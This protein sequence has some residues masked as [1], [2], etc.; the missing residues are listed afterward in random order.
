[1]SKKVHV[2]RTFA[3][4]QFEALEPHRFEDLVRDLLYEYRDWQRIEATGRGGADEGFD[5]RAYEKALNPTKSETDDEEESEGVVVSEGNLWMI[6]CKREKQLSA[7]RIVAIIDEAIHKDDPPYGYVLAAPV[8]FTKKSYDA[9]RSAL[10]ERG[11]FEYQLLGR[12]ELEDMLYQPKNDRVLFAFFGVSL[13]SQKRSRVTSIRATV[14]MKN[15]LYKILGGRGH[16]AFFTD[17]LIRDTDDTEYPNKEAYPDFEN[18]PR[19][20]V[21]TACGH[22]VHGVRFHVR[23]HYA[24]VDVI[25]KEWDFIKTPNLA[26]VVDPLSQDAEERSVK[27]GLRE[28]AE[29]FWDHLPLAQQATFISDGLVPYADI[30]FVDKEG[31]EIHQMPHLYVPFGK[32]GPFDGYWQFL[33]RGKHVHVSLDD[34][35]KID[36]F[37]P[38]LPD[39][40]YGKVHAGIKLEMPSF[41]AY[42]LRSGDGDY[43]LDKTL[44]GP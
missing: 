24:Y 13:V 7:A 4:L 33:Q 5:I 21:F 38:A 31:D 32:T 6:Q 39:I 8:N 37:P 15:K 11:V 17:V 35:A 18:K 44:P 34:M 22:H 40:S 1:M 27:Q 25:K 43:I 36:F 30:D 16:D 10:I 9:F 12:A 41:L 26:R 20:R 42:R 28:R 2:T 14:G 19:W 23:R 29:H 3:P